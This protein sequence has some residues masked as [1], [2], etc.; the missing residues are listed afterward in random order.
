MSSVI[1]LPQ[2][3]R[4]IHR[5]AVLTVRWCIL[6]HRLNGVVDVDPDNEPPTHA[7]SV[8]DRGLDYALRWLPPELIRAEAPRTRRVYLADLD[9]YLAEHRNSDVSPMGG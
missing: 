6:F 3:N 8:D 7:I 2:L 5:Q 9:N 1:D 4:A